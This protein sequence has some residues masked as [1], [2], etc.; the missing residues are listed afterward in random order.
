MQKICKIGEVLD[1]MKHFIK[2]ILIVSLLMLTII[3]S[4]IFTNHVLSKDS[5][6]L[7]EHI[8]NMENYAR[9]NNWIK[10]EEELEFINQYWNKIQKNWA[11][12]QSHFEM[13]YIESALARVAEFVKSRELTLTLAESALLKQSIKHI[14][15]KM[16]FTLENIL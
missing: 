5:K 2:V 3:L 8:V 16:A 6:I 12:L 1:L 9:D 10:A 4:G 13:D 14:P 15:R 11:M 7:E